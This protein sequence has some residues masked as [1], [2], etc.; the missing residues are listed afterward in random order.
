M[1]GGEPKGQKNSAVHTHGDISSGRQ[2]FGTGKTRS[3]T[4]PRHRVSEK[5]DQEG[6]RRWYSRT[7]R[8]S[9]E[10]DEEAMVE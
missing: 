5:S 1:G 10:S 6:Q 8:P 7:K 2:K 4:G 3:L 9:R